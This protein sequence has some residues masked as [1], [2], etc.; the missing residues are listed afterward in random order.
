MFFLFFFVYNFVCCG[1]SKEKDK[2]VDKKKIK[3]SKKELIVREDAA[4]IIKRLLGLSNENS[5]NSEKGKDI[6]RKDINKISKNATRIYDI[7]ELK[8]VVGY[9]FDDQEDY[10][11]RSSLHIKKRDIVDEAIFEINKQIILS[12]NLF[13]GNGNFI[14]EKIFE[15]IES[16]LL[17]AYS[18]IG[19]VKQINSEEIQNRMKKPVVF[20]GRKRRKKATENFSNLDVDS[21][22]IIGNVFFTDISQSMIIDYVVVRLSIPISKSRLDGDI[23]VC[24]LKYCE[25][26]DYF[27]KF[28]DVYNFYGKGVY[29]ISDALQNDKFNVMYDRIIL[30]NNEVKFSRNSFDENKMSVDKVLAEVRCDFFNK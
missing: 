14:I 21:L 26:L 13:F 30:N 27:K 2:D 20:D 22:E 9:S 25:L 11:T 7:D 3:N 1:F 18:D 28:T 15:G 17:K 6:I 16:G 5:S 29:T 23:V 12:E 10:D 24:Y 19:C 4:S 8:R